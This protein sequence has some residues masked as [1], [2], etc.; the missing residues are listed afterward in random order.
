M[1]FY[2]MINGFIFISNPTL[3]PNKKIDHF[4][5]YKDLFYSFCRDVNKYNF[6]WFKTT[7]ERVSNCFLEKFMVTFW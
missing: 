4:Y 5:K 2:N 6:L 1:H 7:T 3:M